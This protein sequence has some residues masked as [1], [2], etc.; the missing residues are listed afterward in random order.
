[1]GGQRKAL[2]VAN[3][4]Y[5]HDGLRHLL[6]PA[7]DADALGQVLGDPQIGDF[8]VQVVH[9]Q[10]SHIVQARIED[11]FSE[12]R[13]DDV[14]LLHFSCHGLKS[15]SGELFFAARNTI[16]NRLGS[17]AVS[18][19]FVQRCMRTSRSRSIV[20]LLDC[21]YG[22]AFGQGV[23]VRA[24]G[25]VNVLDSF[26]AGKLGGGRGRAVITAS[27]AM[28]YAFEGDQLA[29]DHSRRP[30][31]FSAALVEG[32]ATGEADRDEDG[33]V[34]LNEL[35][36]Y[37]FDR[38]REQNPH[39]TPS[40]NVEMQG[41]LYLARSRR[42]RIRPLPIPP[43]LEAAR[44]DPN[45]FTRLGA[46]TE[47][48]SRLASDNV[49]MAAGAHEALTATVRNDIR[50]VAEPAEATLRE[51]AIKPTETELDFGRIEQGSPPPHRTVRLLGPPIARAC[52]PKV[53]DDWIRVNETTDGLD[54]SIDTARAGMLHGSIEVKG[55]T[56]E[57]VITID[58]DISPPA[59]P[60][61]RAREPA[62]NKIPA[63]TPAVT[64]QPE[65]SPAAAPTS[66]FG[67]P[68]AVD[69]DPEHSIAPGAALTTASAQAP[70]EPA[71][72]AQAP[73][74][75]VAIPAPPTP[76]EPRR[77]LA[78]PWLRRQ[79][80]RA[81]TSVAGAWPHGQG[82]WVAAAAIVLVMVAGAAFL[83]RP[84]LAGD[85][86]PSSSGQGSPTHASSTPSTPPGPAPRVEWSAKGAGPITTRPAVDRDRVYFGSG[87]Q[88][89]AVRR[90]SGK[91]AWTFRTSAPVVYAPQIADTEKLLLAATQ[92]G[93]LYAIGS[94]DGQQR[95]RV[96]VGTR[97]Q[98]SPRLVAGGVLIGSDDGGL[99]KFDLA[100]RKQW[101]F[102]TGG[103]V[104]NQPTVDEELVIFGSQDGKLYAVDSRT[105]RDRWT[106]DIGPTSSPN[107]SQ[108]VLLVRGRNRSLY[109]IN[110]DD[111]TTI[112]S[113]KVGSD[114]TH[115][116]AM[117]GPLAYVGGDTA[118]V[119]VNV[120]DG[121]ERWR[122]RIKDGG[123]LGHP[124]VFGGVIYIGSE[125]GRVYAVD[126]STG[127]Q[128]WEFQAGGP[129][130][131][132]PRT[133]GGI[134]YVSSGDGTLYAL[135]PPSVVATPAATS[136]P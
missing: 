7:A 37:V 130:R 116:P 53:S 122:F 128:R 32:L 51:A 27:S 15:D 1:M 107:L 10:P 132:A 88:V 57:A 100:G 110:P 3:D 64:H 79:A 92:D 48:R 71:E 46:V 65:G 90:D 97:T 78:V 16:P 91:D 54:V 61:P 52:I 84:W 6:A 59:T 95:W 123:P 26:P 109:R 44:T 98:S 87:N 82:R 36:D 77:P 86:D 111:G 117:S 62:D 63:P 29:D 30:S 58:V 126:T 4:E 56:G 34:S 73:R 129:V 17:T 49:A 115:P 31:V 103:P 69:P 40:R 38:V 135:R 24:S 14:L 121:V 35:Y 22:G 45:M 39:Q 20:L 80:Q 11:V 66:K 134:V 113:F 70:P 76:R 105:R 94:D 74:E 25:D 104:S 106:A 55:P 127:A 5:E 13:S 89:K 120:S 21:C 96:R 72:S 28:E 68:L 101:R 81:R 114:Q 67:G 99:Y 8:D 50:F 85:A 75:P 125:G 136:T 47:L 12:S 108:G 42:R 112:W 9:N 41:E 118:L 19:D 102:P 131:A 83:V 60:A 124:S 18:A 43:E 33:W 23:S 2:I 119:A 93:Y 133:D